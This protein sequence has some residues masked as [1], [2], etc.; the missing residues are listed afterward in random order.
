MPANHPPVPRA[1]VPTKIFFDPF[2][3]SAT[4]HQRSANRLSGSTSWQKSRTNKLGHQLRDAS[5]R[6]GQSHVS[7]SVGAGS[8][9][10]GKDG[11]KENGDWETDAPGLR[12]E[13]WQD[14]RDLLGSSKRKREDEYSDGKRESQ[15]RSR[16]LLPPEGAQESGPLGGE[17][18]RQPL[19]NSYSEETTVLQGEET[20]TPTCAQLFRGLNLYLNGSTAPLVSDHKL[21]QLWVQRGGSVS[22]GLGRRTVTHVVLG[23][24]NTGG[25]S[26]AS[27]K[28][29]KEV[30]RVG[31]KGVQYIGVR[32]ILDS[33][34]KGKRLSEADYAVGVDKL[35]GARQSSV[36]KMLTVKR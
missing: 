13:G 35:G 6:G 23:Q 25:G 17:K 10:F 14:I 29:Q 24:T 27:S 36:R 21:K 32:W 16:T 3:S 33:I 2:N 30:V 20:P 18:L 34:D 7:D 28:I 11:R 5:G 22:I 1:P 8:E 26:L 9:Q 4:G 19:R 31:G 15:K 12:E